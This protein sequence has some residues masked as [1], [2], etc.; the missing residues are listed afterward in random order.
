MQQHS[1]SLPYCELHGASVAGCDTQASSPGST[2]KQ[3]RCLLLQA[4]CRVPAWLQA[5]IAGQPLRTGGF[6]GGG[7]A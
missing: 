4:E 2:W 6:S 7:T 5:A 1:L 3:H